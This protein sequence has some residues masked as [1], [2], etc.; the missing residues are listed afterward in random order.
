MTTV[1]NAPSV[2]LPVAVRD[3]P[4][5]R[6]TYRPATYEAERIRGLAECLEIVTQNR[7]RLRGWDFPFT[8]TSG[9]KQLEYGSHW[10]AAWSDFWD[11]L[12]YWRFYQSTQFVYLGSVR[13]FTE[14][15]WDARLR[16]SQRLSDGDA[17]SARGFL[18]ITEVIH[19]LTEIMEFAARLSQAGVYREPL[20]ISIQV[21][22]I[23][24]FALAAD[25]GRR[26]NRAYFTSEPELTYRRL[27][28]PAELVAN[29]A[30]E[31]IACSVRFFERFGWLNPD[32]SV[33]R[34]DQQK[35]LRQEY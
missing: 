12:E 8:P 23:E 25:P 7:V 19:N 26:L 33:L 18:S 13:E 29:A 9:D 24:R 6:V 27:F 22:Q 3:Y 31:A 10:I 14:K 28:D 11:H 35:L 21:K 20:E 32:L 1:E 4:H 5:W 34:T 17:A 16:S 30:E 2:Q 15:P